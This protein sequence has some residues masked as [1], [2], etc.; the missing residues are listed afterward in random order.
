VLDGE[1]WLQIMPK[2]V[3]LIGGIGGDAFV[4][5]KRVGEPGAGELLKMYSASDIQRYGTGS[6]IEWRLAQSNLY[7]SAWEVFNGPN[8]VTILPERA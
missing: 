8:R 4:C 6:F 7:S 3:S 5:F 2:E 1:R